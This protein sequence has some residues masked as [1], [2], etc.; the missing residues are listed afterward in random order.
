LFWGCGQNGNKEVN[1]NSSNPILDSFPIK[2][3]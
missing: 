1:G 3:R 2:V